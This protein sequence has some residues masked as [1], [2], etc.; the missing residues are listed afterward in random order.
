MELDFN[1]NYVLL[2]KVPFYIFSESYGGKMNAAISQALNKVESEV[3][4]ISL[5]KS[6]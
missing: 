1:T 2:Q 3:F 4:G 6:S 5:L